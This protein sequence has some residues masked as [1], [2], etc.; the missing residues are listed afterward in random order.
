[1]LSVCHIPPLSSLFTFVCAPQQRLT[2]ESGAI[3]SQSQAV[4]PIVNGGNFL[5]LLQRAMLSKIALR[6]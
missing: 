1:M 4:F 5:R 3:A 6:W 2:S